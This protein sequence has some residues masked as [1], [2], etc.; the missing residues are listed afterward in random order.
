MLENLN[1]FIGVQ[2]VSKTKADKKVDSIIKDIFVSMEQ[3]LC[4]D[5][6]E[7][8]TIQELIEKKRKANDEQSYFWDWMNENGL[9]KFRNL[10]S[11]NLPDEEELHD[12]LDYRDMILQLD[13]ENNIL[14]SYFTSIADTLDE[15]NE[16]N[17]GGV[18]EQ[19]ATF[20]QEDFIPK[21][22]N[23][24]RYHICSEKQK[25]IVNSYKSP[26]RKSGT[27]VILYC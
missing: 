26:T 15:L 13:I 17:Q 10:L 20:E 1:E 22:N 12:L 18:S 24:I 16:L 19:A 23:S 2:R 21:L 11:N 6:K 14:D 25:W 8:K 27:F 4:I 7:Y 3:M 9:V 5:L